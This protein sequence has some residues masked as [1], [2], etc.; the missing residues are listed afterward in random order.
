MKKYSAYT[1][2][3]LRRARTPK[4]RAIGK[5]LFG[6]PI[7][8]R[9]SQNQAILERFDARTVSERTER[10]RFLRSI[11]PRG[12]GFLMPLETSL[13]FS[14]AKMT[15][16]NG[17]FIATVLLAS[18]FIEHRLGAYL[19]GKGFR[20]ESKGGLAAIVAC[21]RDEGLVDYH[22]LA[23]TERLQKIRNP[24]V[25]LK[26]HTHAYNLGRRA[27]ANTRNLATVM[28]ADAKDAL[29][30]MYAMAIARLG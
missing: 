29:S 25:H 3:T 14:E 18:A 4:D 10:L 12:A 27:M 16:I 24:F 13:V 22:L 21:A 23:K 5:D 6:N 28:E 9:K 2:D 8:P 19:E 7:Y 20:K 1:T 15:F 11:F 30:I 26:P 17:E